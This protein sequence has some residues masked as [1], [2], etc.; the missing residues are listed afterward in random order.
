MEWGYA[1][2]KREFRDDVVTE[3]ESWI[4][5]NKEANSNISVADNA[6]AIDPGFEMMSPDQQNEIKK[7][8][9]EALKLWPTHGDG[10]WK[11]KLMLKDSIADVTLQFVLIRPKDYD[12]IATLNLNG[13]YLS[14]ALGRAGRWYRHRARRQYQLRVR[15]RGI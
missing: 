7:E 12:V 3:R 14:D 8:V 1:L 4:L 2:A 5:G 11:S 9:E 13:D 15:P 6:K 10:K